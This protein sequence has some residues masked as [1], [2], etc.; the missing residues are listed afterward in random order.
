M[1]K[2]EI[3]GTLSELAE[4]WEVSKVCELLYI[5]VYKVAQVPLDEKFTITQDDLVR[6]G[7][8]TEKGT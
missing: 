6:V 2:A 8:L 3:T 7:L 5:D 4:L 1:L